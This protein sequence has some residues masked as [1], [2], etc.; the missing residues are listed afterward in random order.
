MQN[1]T[2]VS[3]RHKCLYMLRAGDENVGCYK[4]SRSENARLLSRCVG[5][6]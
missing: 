2:A 1:R 5:G 3:T 4:I 6:V